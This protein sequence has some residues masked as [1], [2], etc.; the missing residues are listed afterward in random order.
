MNT[1][2][3]QNTRTPMDRIRHTILFELGLIGTIV[4]V[5]MLFVQGKNHHVG[6]VAVAI[7]FLAMVWNMLFNYMFD[8][9]LLRKQ[10][11][12]VKSGKQRLAHAI[13]FEVGLVLATVPVLAWSLDLTLGQAFIADIGFVVFA[14]FYA[15]AF[16][17]IYDKVFPVKG[18]NKQGVTSAC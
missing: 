15:G 2:I 8:A 17:L 12:C 6:A 16:N 14:L 7:S 3:T 18:V 4:P 9:Y 11:H 5:G 1:N 10:N 13:L